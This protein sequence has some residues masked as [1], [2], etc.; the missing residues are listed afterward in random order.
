[1]LARLLAAS[2]ADKRRPSHHVLLCYPPPPASNRAAGQRQWN[3]L[4]VKLRVSTRATGS[5]VAVSRRWGSLHGTR[6]APE[7]LTARKK[8]GARGVCAV[9]PRLRGAR[10]IATKRRARRRTSVRDGA[11]QKPPALRAQTPTP[12]AASQPR[13][14]TP[15]VRRRPNGAVP[16]PCTFS[17]SR[18]EDYPPCSILLP[19]AWREVEMEN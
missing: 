2:N 6:N 14:R 4:I 15:C 9:K 19:R 18:S 11:L 10:R 7:P 13:E 5:I 1:M 3:E 8:A 16:E 17:T 12:T